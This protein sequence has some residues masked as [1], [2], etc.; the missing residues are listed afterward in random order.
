M[1]TGLQI[2]ARSVFM[3]SRLAPPAR[4]GMTPRVDQTGLR[5]TPYEKFAGIC[6]NSLT[7]VGTRD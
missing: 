1:D 3:D 2:L 7:L 6:Q 4:P 5:I